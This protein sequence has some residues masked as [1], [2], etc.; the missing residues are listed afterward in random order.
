MA[1]VS[2]AQI[3]A[4]LKKAG[5]RSSVMDVQDMIKNGKVR[6]LA[7]ILLKDG[8]EIGIAGTAL[9]SAWDKR[10]PQIESSINSFKF[11]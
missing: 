5:N 4:E 1:D 6:G 3:E 11:E 2:D 9:G 10:G 7:Y 8:Y